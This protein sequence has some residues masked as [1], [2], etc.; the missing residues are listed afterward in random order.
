MT[1]DRRQTGRTLTHNCRGRN[2]AFTSVLTFRAKAPGVY[3]ARV[4][5]HIQQVTKIRLLAFWGSVR[6]GTHRVD[7]SMTELQ[8]SS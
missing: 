3:H 1:D 8:H 4:N 7:A 6:W 5:S 2:E